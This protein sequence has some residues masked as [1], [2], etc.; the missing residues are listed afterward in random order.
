VRK[1]D[2]KFSNGVVPLVNIS[3]IV[4]VPSAV[5]INMTI[6]KNSPVISPA[7][8]GVNINHLNS[9]LVELF[10]HQLFE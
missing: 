3:P 10:Y 2:I 6:L 8:L 1:G 7:A 5:H 4:G 9:K